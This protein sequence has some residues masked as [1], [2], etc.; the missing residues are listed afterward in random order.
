MAL[1]WCAAGMVE[2]DK[3]FVEQRFGGRCQRG[4]P[5][6]R[7]DGEA[8][9]VTACI[10]QHC[11]CWVHQ[12]GRHG[13]LGRVRCEPALL[14][15]SRH[16]ITEGQFLCGTLVLP[17]LGQNERR[18]SATPQSRH[19]QR[20]L[21][22]PTRGGVGDPA[23]IVDAQDLQA[24]ATE[25]VAVDVGAVSASQAGVSLRECSPPFRAGSAAAVL[26]FF[27]PAQADGALPDRPLRPPGCHRSVRR[28]RSA[29][30]AAPGPPPPTHARPDTNV[31][32]LARAS[33][34]PAPIPRWLGTNKST[35][36]LRARRV[37]PGTA[38]C[39]RRQARSTRSTVPGSDSR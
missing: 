5:L 11:L 25:S 3:Q 9:P 23:W 17:F 2:A 13:R 39:S 22:R 24:G 8:A 31:D 7:T 30:S 18:C 35:D 1:R 16:Q 19:D 27:A 10:E 26:P 6:H 33:R 29:G 32:K 38:R 14:L 28:Q 20:Q 34:S 21:H 37:C 12:V 4:Q 15:R 36:Q